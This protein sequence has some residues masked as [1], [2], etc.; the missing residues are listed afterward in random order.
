MP[1]FPKREEV[2]PGK[3]IY[4]ERQTETRTFKDMADLQAEIDQIDAAHTKT[5]PNNE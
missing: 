3:T 1:L 5:H 2:P 4:E